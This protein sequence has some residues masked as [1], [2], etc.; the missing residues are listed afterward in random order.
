MIEVEN[1]SIA[2]NLNLF[3]LDV[4]F[5]KKKYPSV[6][7]EQNKGK[8]E[9]LDY[10]EIERIILDSGPVIKQESVVL[11]LSNNRTQVI[12]NTDI[13]SWYSYEYIDG[14]TVKY[15]SRFV[16]FILSPVWEQSGFLGIWDANKKSWI[17]DYYDEGFCVEVVL[18]SD[19]L[20]TFFGYYEWNIPMSPKHGEKFFMI[21]KNRSY[22][23]IGAEKIYDASC[24]A[25]SD[26]D[27]LDSYMPLNMDMKSQFSSNGG[28][29]LIVDI[30]QKLAIIHDRKQ[31]KILSAYKLQTLGFV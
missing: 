4:D 2:D 13:L 6:V 12:Y 10:P 9:Y 16:Y 31:K 18:Y 26:V 17:F 28:M 11:W 25:N 14:Y 5:L 22:R 20:D 27:F 29:W 24:C 30:K 19:E 1:I 21:D 7:Y 3:E 23:E 15:D 8:L